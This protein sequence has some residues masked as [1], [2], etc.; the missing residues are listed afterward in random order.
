VNEVQIGKLMMMADLDNRWVYKGSMTTPPCETGV[1]WNIARRVF[2]IK[3]LHYSKLI[4]IQ[5]ELSQTGFNFRMV[6][7][8]DQHDPAIIAT[9]TKKT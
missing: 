6:N 5:R 7:E 9:E 3:V 2:P 4:E 8:L 1:Y